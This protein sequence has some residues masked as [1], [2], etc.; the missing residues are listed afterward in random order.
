M[1]LHILILFY[2]R[3]NKSWADCCRDWWISSRF[4]LNSIITT[5]NN[6]INRSSNKHAFHSLYNVI[7]VYNECI[8]TVFGINKHRFVCDCDSWLQLGSWS[9]LS[10]RLCLSFHFS[11]S[12][13]VVL[14]HCSR[15]VLGH[16]TD[17]CCL[18]FSETLT[19]WLWVPHLG[20]SSFSC[21]GLLDLLDLLD[22]SLS[23]LTPRR[24]LLHLPALIIVYLLWQWHTPQKDC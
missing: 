5:H 9:S 22:L 10:W 24:A 15:L 23:P 16:P 3:L 18:W 4:T 14:G 12:C 21:C 17:A 19:L 1:C 2:L 20:P 8:V 6:T 13:Q 11:K 7:R